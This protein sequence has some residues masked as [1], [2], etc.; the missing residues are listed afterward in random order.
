VRKS[1][2]KIIVH[3]GKRKR[4]KRLLSRCLP[5]LIVVS[6]YETVC[7]SFLQIALRKLNESVHLWY[8]SLNFLETMLNISFEKIFYEKKNM[9]MFWSINFIYILP[10][11][12]PL[13]NIYWL[14]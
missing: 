2:V 3:N 14:V 10:V 13:N 5:L 9:A 12:F 7:Y 4:K 11:L 8:F 1:D 6:F